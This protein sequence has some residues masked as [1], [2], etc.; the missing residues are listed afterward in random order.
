LLILFRITPYYFD[1]FNELVGG[2]RNVYVHKL[3][4]LG[5]WGEGLKDAGMYVATNAPDTS[6]I[7]LAINPNHNILYRKNTLVY[8]SFTPEKS[9]DYVIVN[10]FNVTRLGFDESVLK[11]KYKIVH[12]VIAD[13][14]EL[15][16]VYKHL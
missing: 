13:G 16:R 14:A 8:E 10:E 4:F 9:Y 5:W 2:T 1:Y 15:V 12:K 11:K 6:R 3:F 7:G